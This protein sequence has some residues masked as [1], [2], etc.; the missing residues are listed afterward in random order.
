LYIVQRLKLLLVNCHY[1]VLQMGLC[2]PI[3]IFL[4]PRWRMVAI[5]KTV[6]RDNIST[7]V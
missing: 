1:D 3:L 6:K 4:L 7:T 2:I 5:L